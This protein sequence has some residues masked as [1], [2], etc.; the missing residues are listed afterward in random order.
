M[1]IYLIFKDRFIANS[2]VTS[3]MTILPFQL[4]LKSQLSPKDVFSDE[5]GY[6]SWTVSLE[7]TEAGGPYNIT[8]TL[9]EDST[10]ITLSNQW[11]IQDFPEEGALT[12]KGGRQPIIWPI[13]PKNCMKMKKFLARGGALGT[14]PPLRSATGN[15]M[16]GDV[17]FCSGQSNMVWPVFLVS[18][19]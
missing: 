11:R 13:F 10:S 8:A 12:L 3:Q 2:M 16:F 7:P 15:V 4:L 9:V 17:Y 1:A 5:L 18:A 6:V 19:C 14:R